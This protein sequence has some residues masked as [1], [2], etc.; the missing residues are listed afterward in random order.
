MDRLQQHEQPE[1]RRARVDDLDDLMA[2]VQSAYRGDASRSGWTTEADLIDGSRIDAPTMRATLVDP[3]VVVLV[4]DDEHGRP[5]ACCELRRDVGGGAVTTFGMFAV[6]PDLQGAGLG[7]HLLRA[8]ERTARDEWAADRLR[9]TVIDRRQ[10]LIEWYGRRGYVA[11]GE[12]QPFPYGDERFGSPRVD[13]LRFAVLERDLSGAAT[14][15]R[16][17]GRPFDLVVHGATSFVGQILCRYLVAEHGTHGPI[18]WAISGRNVDKLGDVAAATG[19]EVE[20]IV[21]DSHDP[22]ALEELCAAT[23]VVVSTV[24]PYARYGSELV[25]AAVRNGTDYLDLTGETQWMRRMI[26]AH[27]DEAVVSGARVV[28]ACGFDSIPSDLGVWFTQQ[29]SIARHG[30]PCDHISMRVDDLRGGA[31]GG[32]V[33][34][35]LHLVEEAAHDPV[36][37]RLLAD[38]YAL[39]PPDRRSGPRQPEVRRPTLDP[40]SPGRWL[41]PF[42]MAAVNTRVVQRSH[43]LLDRPWGDGFRYDEAMDMGRGPLGAAKAGAVSAGLAGVLG[44]AALGPSRKLLE[45]TVL[46]SPGDGPTPAAQARGRF[47]LRFVG[48]TPSGSTITSRVTGDRDPGYGATARMLGEAAAAMVDLDPADTGGGFW[49]PA[50][51]FGD[52]LIERL[53]ARAGLRFEVLP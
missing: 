47:S 4:V 28:H 33:A 43:A 8:A 49:T 44:L 18:R 17:R 7:G 25:A 6:D 12:H 24:G 37:R 15:G 50:T 3:R 11:T 52:V 53:E 27:H 45:R 48:H 23:T 41:A 14:N 19:A 26:D 20:R 38:P 21:A 42:V 35:M 51:A 30:E 2:L 16:G 32:T 22:A 13:D 9:L 1:I 36:L 31:S 46:P 34:S 10:E 40:E 29:Q 39:N 5:I